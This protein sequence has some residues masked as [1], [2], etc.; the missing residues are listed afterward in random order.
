M[1]WNNP[2]VNA[3]FLRRLAR[4][5][6]VMDSVY[7]QSVCSPSRAALLT[8]L[9]PIFTAECTHVMLNWYIGLN[10]NKLTSNHKCLKLFFVCFSYNSNKIA[11]F[12]MDHIL[13]ICLSNK[14]VHQPMSSNSASEFNVVNIDLPHGE[15]PLPFVVNFVVGLAVFLQNTKKRSIVW[16]VLIFFTKY[17]IFTN[18][19]NVMYLPGVGT[20]HFTV[21]SRSSYKYFFKK[22]SRL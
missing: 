6:V 9:Y 15:N 21:A 14:K 10:P 20:E 17:S 7:S 1:P 18:T 22:I 5:G 3:P 4:E 13:C 8:G 19:W 2:H 11:S 16:K 12:V